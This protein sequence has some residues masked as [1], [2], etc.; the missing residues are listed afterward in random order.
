[1]L[2]FV[3]LSEYLLPPVLKFCHLFYQQIVE[4]NPDRITALTSYD[5]MVEVITEGELPACAAP[6]NE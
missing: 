1:M 5:D 4:R 3:A 6:V 2:D